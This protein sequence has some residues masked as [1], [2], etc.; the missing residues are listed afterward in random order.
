MRDPAA[1]LEQLGAEAQADLNV[2]SVK[3]RKPAEQIEWV[4]R[5]IGN[6][7]GVRL[8]MACM[9]GKIHDSKFDPRNRLKKHS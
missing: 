3:S 7:A 8:L 9:L 2:R 1:I 6:R 4:C 5:C